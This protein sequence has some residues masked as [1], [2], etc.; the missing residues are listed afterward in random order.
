MRP[1][2]VELRPRSAE[3]RGL[4]FIII[5]YY[6]TLDL[7]SRLAVSNDGVVLFFCLFF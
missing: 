6:G 3:H 5:F 1:L 2:D 7:S 4:F